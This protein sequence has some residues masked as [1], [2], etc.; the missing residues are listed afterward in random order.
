MS[1]KVV[2][3]PGDEEASCSSMVVRLFSVE[4]RRDG[5]WL[6]PNPDLPTTVND[7][8]NSQPVLLSQGTYSGLVALG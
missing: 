5:H 7:D 6:L 8:P 4:A 3:S 2:V 1:D